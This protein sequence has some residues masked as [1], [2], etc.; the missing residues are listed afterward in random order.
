MINPCE[1]IDSAMQVPSV[2]HFG[3]NQNFWGSHFA[4]TSPFHCTVYAP[5]ER[6]WFGPIREDIDSAMKVPSVGHFEKN[7]NFWGSHFAMTSLFH[8]TVNIFS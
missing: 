1:G 4:M 6:A 3:K 7:Q 2:G 5:Q 8:C